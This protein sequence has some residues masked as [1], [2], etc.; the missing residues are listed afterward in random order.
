VTAIHIVPNSNSE[1]QGVLLPGRFFGVLDGATLSTGGK[2]AINVD[3]TSG[4]QS[5]RITVGAAAASAFNVALVALGAPF[6]GIDVRIIHNYGE[7]N[8]QGLQ[9][10]ISFEE[11]PPNS[12]GDGSGALRTL[13]NNIQNGGASYQVGMQT[14]G[15][16]LTA[17]GCSFAANAPEG[18]VYVDPGDI[19][20]G[21]DQLTTTIDDNTGAKFKA[22]PNV[23]YPAGRADYV[24]SLT[25]NNVDSIPVNEGSTQP[26]RIVRID[27]A[28]I[29]SNWL[30][31]VD[32]VANIVRLAHPGGSDIRRPRDIWNMVWQPIIQ[33]SSLSVADALTW[34][35]PNNVD[36]GGVGGRWK[37]LE[38][39]RCLEIAGTDITQTGGGG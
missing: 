36:G 10:F 33:S 3:T 9:H 8:Y 29:S 19:G 32:G 28:V 2:Q 35:S 1:S 31:V 24:R 39:A 14:D 21:P 18:A 20:T 13:L 7:A 34:T 27:N 22:H 16:V 6:N 38:Y 4:R 26:F 17:E 11:Q 37:Y 5:P 12:D 30:V 25:R 15:T 23:F